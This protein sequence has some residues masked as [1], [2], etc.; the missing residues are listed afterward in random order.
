MVNNKER[1]MKQTSLVDSW[2]VVSDDKPTRRTYII[3]G[4]ISTISLMVIV[5][6]SLGWFKA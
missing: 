1:E 6:V 4:A 2:S 5:M 3:L